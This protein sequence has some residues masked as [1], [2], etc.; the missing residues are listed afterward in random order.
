MKKA[1]KKLASEKSYKIGIDIGGTKIEIILLDPAD[2][3]IHRKRIST[4]GQ[5][6]YHAILDS[7]NR[8]C[9]ETAGLIPTGNDYTV[10]IGIPGIV[11]VETQLVHNANTTCLIGK[12][13][14]NDIENL[15]GMRI[16]IENDAKCFTLA[17]SLQG[18]AKG[19]G[20]VFGIIMG[21]GCGGG[22]CIDGKIRQGRHGI[23]GE[24]GHFSVDPNG[25][26]CYCGNRGCVETKISGSGVEYAFFR[27]YGKRL[28]MA[29]IVRGYRSGD[30]PECSEVFTQFLD[31]FGR[32]VGGLISLLDPDAVVLGG[33]L[34]NIDELYNEGIEQVKK[35]A[36]HRNIKTPILKNKL[37][38][39]AGV[40][41]AAWAGNLEN[42][43]CQLDFSI[44]L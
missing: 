14:Q 7:I 40:F 5:K 32:C 1:N 2:K 37:G 17:E 12:P 38:D 31:D 16:A 9:C 39:S 15:I 4:P 18:A 8:L 13:F 33:G 20:F 23:A 22:I 6:G 3:E 35:Y 34:S 27:K 24:W 10:G 42:I 21:T 43:N 25:A 36:F 41:G 19:F 44:A 30:E 26:K 28:K 29:E 11:D